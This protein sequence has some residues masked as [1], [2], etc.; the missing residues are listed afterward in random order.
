MVWDYDDKGVVGGVAEWCNVC[1]GPRTV[2][3]W[4]QL[5][6]GEGMSDSSERDDFEA[7]ARLDFTT[8]KV[9]VKEKIRGAIVGPKYIEINGVCLNKGEARLLARFILE[10]VGSDG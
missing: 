8:F 9:I 6:R 4:S 1:N 10:M 3:C 2:A 5:E 7:I